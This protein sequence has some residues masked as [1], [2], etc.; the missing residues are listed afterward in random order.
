[1]FLGLI[2]ALLFYSGI[3]MNLNVCVVNEFYFMLYYSTIGNNESWLMKTQAK[4][5]SILNIL[6]P[7]SLKEEV[8]RC[9]NRNSTIEKCSAVQFNTVQY[10]NI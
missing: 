3:K 8:C 9:D 1:M 10:Y 2:I 7:G 5:K 6:Y 4:Y